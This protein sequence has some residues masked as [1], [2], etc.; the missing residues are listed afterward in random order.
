MQS[1]DPFKMYDSRAIIYEFY[2]GFCRNNCRWNLR[3]TT[4]LL[5]ITVLQS[6]ALL[7]Q[8]TRM[9]LVVAES[10]TVVVVVAVVGGQGR[11]C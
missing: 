2:L 11:S 5:Q 1:D 6:V 7:L 9:A 4:D 8:N 3:A 10:R